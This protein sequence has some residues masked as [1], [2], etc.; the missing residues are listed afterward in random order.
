ME[1]EIE[2]LKCKIETLKRE[3]AELRD[4]NNKLKQSLDE[5]VRSTRPQPASRGLEPS[6][7][8]SQTSSET[9]D[10]GTDSEVQ[11]QLNRAIQQLSETRQQ[12]LNVQDR[13]TV[14]E[15][16]TAATQRRELIQEGAYQNLPSTSDYEELRFDPT[17][18]HVYAELK[19]TTHTGMLFSVLFVRNFHSYNPFCLHILCDLYVTFM[20]YF[21]CRCFLRFDVLNN[22][23]VF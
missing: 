1:T 19:P 3:N 15:Q 2:Q 21:H 12:L 6:N 18:E 5:A 14:T 10:S 20:R 17:Q 23:V 11:Q 16:V 7:L 13:L 4:I 22:G 8:Q 9:A